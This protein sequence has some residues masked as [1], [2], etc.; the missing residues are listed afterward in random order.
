MT[1]TL[2]FS[3]GEA[4]FAQLEIRTSSAEKTVLRYDAER[5]ELVF[6]R[7]QSSLIVKDTD[8]FAFPER[9]PVSLKDGK[10]EVRVISDRAFISVFC[11]GQSAFSAIFPQAVSDGMKLYADGNVGADVTIYSLSGIF[12]ET[13]FKQV[14]SFSR[15]QGRARS[16]ELRALFRRKRSFLRSR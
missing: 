10:L 2:D 8:Y 6:D 3:A 11:N 14:R 5:E 1:A 13:E 9:I 7:S 16:F 15:R 4:S 12:G